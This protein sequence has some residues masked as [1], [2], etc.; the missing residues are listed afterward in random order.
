MQTNTF[1][2]NRGATS[3]LYEFIPGRRQLWMRVRGVLTPG[4]CALVT[5]DYDR[6]TAGS[7]VK[8]TVVDVSSAVIALTDDQILSASDCISPAVL[9]VPAAFVTSDEQREL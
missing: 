1:T 8:S 2:R 6:I 5:Q 3:V 7:L 9:D 4:T